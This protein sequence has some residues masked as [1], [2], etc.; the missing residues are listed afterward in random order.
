MTLN[1]GKMSRKAHVERRS[2]GQYLLSHTKKNY[3]MEQVHHGKTGLK[4]AHGISNINESHP[5]VI[6]K[7]HGGEQST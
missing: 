5:F 3:L 4:F 2:V 6:I 7:L 1:H